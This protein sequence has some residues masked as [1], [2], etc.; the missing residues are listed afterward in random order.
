MIM[1]QENNKLVAEF[2]GL[3]DGNKYLSPSLEEPESI[4]LGTYVDTDEMRYH[5]SWDWLK[6]VVDEIEIKHEGVPQQLLHLSLF[7][8]R[9]EVYNAVIQFIKSFNK[10]NK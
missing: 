8:T 9:D 6:R 1:T 3:K 4:G 10:Q 5:K 7:S 2:M